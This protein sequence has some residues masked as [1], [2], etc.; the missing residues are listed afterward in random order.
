MLYSLFRL[1]TLLAALAALLLASAEKRGEQ[2]RVM[3][4]N[5]DCRVRLR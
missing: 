5:I 1:P 2:F 3:S 4:F